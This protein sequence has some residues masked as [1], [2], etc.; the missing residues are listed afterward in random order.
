MILF[1]LLLGPTPIS[2]GLFALGDGPLA[3]T[4]TLTATALLVGAM[5][6]LY[7]RQRRDAARCGLPVLPKLQVAALLSILAGISLG[8]FLLPITEVAAIGFFA[9]VAALA[10]I[11]GLA[12]KLRRE[13]DGPDERGAVLMLALMACLIALGNACL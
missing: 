11:F 13:L 10:L 7:R 4:V 2:V 9:L 1:L 6:E 8:T 3:M 12:L 5:L